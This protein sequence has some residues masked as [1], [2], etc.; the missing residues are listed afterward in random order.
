MLFEVEVIAHG[1]SPMELNRVFDLISEPKP[2]TRV[3]TADPLGNDCWCEVTGWSEFGQSP[4]F[5]AMAE[6]SGDGVVLLVYGADD[7][8]RLKRV[9]CQENWRLTS[10]N[11]WGEP[12]LMLDKDTRVE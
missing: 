3:F 2:I 10:A 7:G 8:I 11:Q 12:C 1:N 5:A 6:D 4:A 9:E